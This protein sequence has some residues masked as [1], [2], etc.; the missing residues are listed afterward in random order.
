[1]LETFQVCPNPHT[2]LCIPLMT[3]FRKMPFY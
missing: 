3:T 1:L 2:R